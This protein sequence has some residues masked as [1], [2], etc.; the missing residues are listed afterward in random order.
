[1]FLFSL[2]FSPTS[3]EGFLLPLSLSWGILL[4][5]LET[6]ALGAPQLLGFLLPHTGSIYCLLLPR[7]ASSWCTHV[8]LAIFSVHGFLDLM[9]KLD[10]KGW[11]FGSWVCLLLLN[12]L[13]FSG[14]PPTPSLAMP[15]I[16]EA[17]ILPAPWFWPHLCIR[18]TFRDFE[19][20]HN[21]PHPI[22]MKIQIRS[23][24]GTH[25]NFVHVFIF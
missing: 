2:S 17:R 10:W 20:T 18:T 7:P 15:S 8:W 6:K 5:F 23:S 1:M 4:S 21:W 25:V 22:P 12:L 14:A 9:G 16:P 19:T 24:G 11:E 3:H 13:V